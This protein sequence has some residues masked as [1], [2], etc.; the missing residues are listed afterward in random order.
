MQ[1]L[2]LSI[3]SDPSVIFP[4]CA[5]WVPFLCESQLIFILRYWDRTILLPVVLYGCKTWSLTLTEERRLRVF[6]NRVLRRISGPK[7]HEATRKWRRL[8]NEELC[9][10]YSLP[11]VIR[12]IKS[13]RL[14]WTRHLARMGERRGIFLVLVGKPERRRPLGKPRHR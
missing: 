1:Y 10:L 9:A 7:R 13:R 12:V 4:L 11:N 8:H 5:W 6:E 14:R 2:C 3:G